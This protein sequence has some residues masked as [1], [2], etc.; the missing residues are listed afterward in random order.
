MSQENVEIVKAWYDAFNREDWDAMIKDAAPGFELD[1]SR[2]TGPVS[3]VFGLD[4]IRRMLGEF[5]EL[6]E[7]APRLESHELIEA[8]DLVVVPST[9]HLK[10][11]GGIEVSASATFVWTIRNGAIERAVMYQEKEDALEDLGLSE[12]DATP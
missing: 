1:F 3:G 9:Q 12:Q 5:R 8:G 4:Q 2:A 7:S 6:W 10:G 11:R